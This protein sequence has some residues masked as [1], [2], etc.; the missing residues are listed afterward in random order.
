MSGVMW[1]IFQNNAG[2]AWDNA[3]KSF[4][5][6]VEID[7]EM[8]YKGSEAHKAAVTGDTVGDPFKDTSGP[9][10]NIL[11]KLT[12]LV[13]L[14]IAPILGEGHDSHTAVAENGEEMMFVSEDGTKTIL[15]NKD[16]KEVHEEISKE[17]K[18]EMSD[19]A[20]GKK[21]VV[22][23]TTEKN[24]EKKTET[25]TIVGTEEEVK[26]QLEELQEEGVHVKKKMVKEV[27]KEVEEETKN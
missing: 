11:I 14:V 9:S 26:A 5:A 27:V 16:A 13:G 1:A 6:G 19:D 2:G 20:A 4:E 8:T 15:V 3:K 18:V 22:T 21:A 12:C 7:G 10:M 23:I 17:I 24:G 25:K